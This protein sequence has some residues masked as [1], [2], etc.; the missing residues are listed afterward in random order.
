MYRIGEKEAEA[1]RK[2]IKKGRPFRYGGG[3]FCQKFEQQYGKY[4]GAK[5]V[6]QTSSGTA[7]LTAAMMGLGIGPGDE[8]LVPAHTYMASAAAVL[9][10]GAIP[11]IVDI[12]ES[13]MIDPRAIDDAVGPCTRAVMPCHLW[14][15]VSDMGAIMR[16]ARKHKLLVIEDACQAIGG[17][18]RG[19][20]LGTIGNVGAYSFNF[21]KHITCGEGG[22]VVTNN[23]RVLERINC[24]V[25]CANFF[26]NKKKKSFRGF[27]TNSSRASEFEGAMLSVQLERLPGMLRPL[28]Q[29][30]KRIIKE[31]SDVLTHIPY[32]DIDGDC[33]QSFAFR[34]ETTKL[35]QKFAELTGG[36]LV[37]RTGRHNFFDWEPILNHEGA[38]HP[39]MNPYNMPANR[40]CRKN[41]PKNM[42]KQTVDVVN[43]TVKFNNHPD[44]KA[45]E[46]NALIRKIKSAAKEL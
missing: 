14:G 3:G 32:H 45:K 4:L 46:V 1:V 12:D 33:G 5:Y 26:W 29:Q 39:A 34:F 24:A 9:A 2:V 15:L 25:D 42:C 10:V 27:V 18:Y 23:A 22:A 11:V 35:A 17:S 21:Y 31:T 19:K 20:M 28:R 44:R 38:H 8:V 41:Y 30:K 36:G 6:V 7:A 13:L 40:K 16:V 37:S 43:R